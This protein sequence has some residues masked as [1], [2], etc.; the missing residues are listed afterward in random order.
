MLLKHIGIKSKKVIRVTRQILHCDMNNFY[1]SVECALNPE[2]NGKAIAVCGNV[3]E[4]KGIVLA[5]NQ[6]AKDK[7]VKT[8]D[9]VWTARQKCPGIVIVPPRFDEYVKAS[10]KAQE[11]YYRYTNLIEPYGLDECWLDVTNSFR[12]F[13]DGETIANSIRQDVKDQLGLTISVG[14]SFN[15]IFAKLGSDMKKP[16]AVT[17]ISK[18]NFKQKVWRLNANELI[19][20]GSS[21]Y[22]KL[23]KYNIK[24]LGDLACADEKLI[25]R[26]L[27]KVGVD[28]WNY[29]NG[30]DDSRV[31]EYTEFTHQKSVSN[32]I[33]CNKDLIDNYEVYR[34]MLKLSQDVA[35][36]LR[37]LGIHAK[38]VQISIKNSQLET[39][40]WQA[41][42]V[43]S[44]QSFNEITNLAHEIFIKNYNWNNNV[45]AISVG[46]SDLVGQPETQQL[47][48][49]TDLSRNTNKI[50]LEQAMEGIRSRF[51]NESIELASLTEDIKISKD[52][53]DAKVLPSGMKK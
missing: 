41:P 30:R 11:I 25:T 5:K 42:F 49:F 39:K 27:G 7:D 34:V 24:T 29:A 20:I 35:K 48:L 33:T 43:S 47:D 8:G 21:T 51:G 52:K 22:E 2:L 3:D 14:V 37:I 4:R 44:T 38:K 23:L 31:A 17:V 6:M 13:G 19:G 12:L 50:K 26:I 15:K 18:E 16:D 45:R 10:K 9:T 46:V 53:S 1:A 36:R 40:Q 28:L 32:G